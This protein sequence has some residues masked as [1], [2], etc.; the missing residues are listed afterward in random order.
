MSFIFHSENY[1]DLKVG[2]VVEVVRATD[3]KNN[4]KSKEKEQFIGQKFVIQEISDENDIH[5]DVI[6]CFRL[7]G[8]PH[9]W[10]EEQIKKID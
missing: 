6:A 7:Q 9:W 8:N 2:D 10:Y 5:G 3:D 1:T 4:Y